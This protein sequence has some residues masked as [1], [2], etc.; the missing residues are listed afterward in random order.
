MV[1]T[2]ISESLLPL[3]VPLCPCDIMQR[4]NRE[5]VLERKLTALLKILG[6]SQVSDLKKE[7]ESEY[8]VII[9]YPRGTRM[10]VKQNVAPKKSSEVKGQTR[11]WVQP[12]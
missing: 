11:F 12:C 9:Q 10:V 4:N 7:K 3:S 1:S 8:I 2:G 6:S 5:H